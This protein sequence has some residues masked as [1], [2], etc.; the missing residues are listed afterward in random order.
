MAESEGAFK[1]YLQET[2]KDLSEN[3]KQINLKPEKGAAIKSLV[4]G[5]DVLVI[6]A[7]GF[8]VN[9][10]DRP[11]MTPT[12]RAIRTFAIYFL[13]FR[14]FCRFALVYE[15]HFVLCYTEKTRAVRSC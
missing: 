4:H 12:V 2:F 14:S 3:S 7:P 1:F 15:G 13:V 8:D 10:I 5:Q 9:K 11:N 6:L